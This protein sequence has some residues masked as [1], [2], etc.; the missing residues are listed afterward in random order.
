MRER[1]PGSFARP[2]VENLAEQG[3]RGN[4]DEDLVARAS[5]FG[6][7][8]GDECLAGAARHERGG[9]VVLAQ[10]GENV[11]ESF[12][13]MRKRML[14]RALDFRAFEP[15]ADRREVLRGEFVEIVAGDR[16]ETGALLHHVGEAVA[17]GDQHA[18]VNAI[19]QADEGGKL[20]PRQRRPAGAELRLIGVVCAERRLEDAVHAFV[21]ESQRQPLPQ[22][23]RNARARPDLLCLF[24][25]ERREIRLD[26]N[27]ERV[28]AF[29]RGRQRADAG[30]Q[31][32]KAY[33]PVE[34][35]ALKI[36]GHFRMRG[37]V[38][39]F[40]SSFNLTTA[41]LAPLSALP[42]WQPWPGGRPR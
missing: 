41:K 8:Q 32:A 19:R 12:V 14:R 5:S 27:L 42:W 6:S 1:R 28:A 31:F 26:E 9:A 4:E 29:L 16:V 23:R 7:P 36:C 11:A 22:R 13:L 25:G 40:V 21:A 33:Q 37:T 35:T 39:W 34:N 18:L 30:F 3:E 15:C 2:F 20:V 24:D 38:H 10:R 17:V